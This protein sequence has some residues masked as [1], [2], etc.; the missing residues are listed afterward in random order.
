MGAILLVQSFR[1][2]VFYISSQ[3]DILSILH[4]TIVILLCVLLKFGD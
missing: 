3:N 1:S 2:T 4:L